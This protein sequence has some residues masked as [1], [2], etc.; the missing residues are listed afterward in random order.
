MRTPLLI[1]SVL[2]L[3]GALPSL[4][5]AQSRSLPATSS[6]AA[7]DY[8]VQ[9]GDVL[10]IR[11]WP[12]S[13]FNGEFPVEET[14]FAYLPLI[15]Q[16]DVGGRSIRDLRVELRHAYGEDLKMPVVT[17]TPVFRVSVLGAVRAPGLYHVDPTLTLLDVI[18]MAG[19]FTERARQDHIRVIRAGRE[20]VRIRAGRALESGEALEGVALQSGDRIVVPAGSTWLSARNVWQFMQAAI[21]VVTLINVLQR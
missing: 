19:G 14:G 21:S 4:T 8:R 2:V 7:V 20:T 11:V 3:I 5:G 18:S 15:G 1:A 13:S 10:R 17:I 16:I 12:D 9:A 6:V